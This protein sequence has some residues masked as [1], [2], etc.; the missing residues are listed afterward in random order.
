VEAGQNTSTI[1]L[2]VIGSDRKP[3]LGALYLRGVLDSHG[4]SYF[5]SAIFIAATGPKY[6]SLPSD[7]AAAHS[8]HY[9]TAILRDSWKHSMSDST[10]VF[11]VAICI[12]MIDLH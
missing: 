12:A 4:R 7:N 5:R 11:H 1:A 8:L 9:K 10:A 3:I 2:Q 6:G